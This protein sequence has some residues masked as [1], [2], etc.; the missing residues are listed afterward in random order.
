MSFLWKSLQA[1]WPG[2][3]VEEVGEDGAEGA[4]E[5]RD[6]E[7][8][9]SNE[10]RE[11][12]KADDDLSYS[13]SYEY[14]TESDEDDNDELREQRKSASQLLKEMTRKATFNVRF[15]RSEFPRTMEGP[16][17]RYFR[18]PMARHVW[19]RT[20]SCASLDQEEERDFGMCDFELSLAGVD[21]ISIDADE[22]QMAAAFAKHQTHHFGATNAEEVAVDPFRLW[23]I[24]TG[25]NAYAAR[26][27]FDCSYSTDGPR[28][29]I[30]CFERFGRTATPISG[31]RWLVIGGEHEDS[32]DPDFCIYNDVVL[33]DSRGSVRMFEYPRDIFP[34]TDF[35]TATALDGKLYLIGN[36]GYND[37]RRPGCTQVLRLDLTTFEVENLETSGNG[38]GWLHSHTAR[39]C[40]DGM[41]I[42]VQGGKVFNAEKKIVANEATHQL[43]TK[44]LEWSCLD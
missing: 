17:R 44:T 36:L 5:E 21:N 1:L 29:P 16:C 41:S 33:F 24:K 37:D 25:G 7:N 26:S 3:Q 43:D 15:E 10:T 13:S 18:I 38:P 31:Q 27:R 40:S 9:N 22:E 8:A 2:E 32:Y 35:H 23:M 14:E 20:K 6:L 11:G 28:A 30:W 4:A 12:D 42:Q 39:V 34:P 19:R